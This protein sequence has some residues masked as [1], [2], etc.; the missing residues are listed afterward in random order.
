MAA[1]NRTN[2]MSTALVLLMILSAL[3]PMMA[4]H[5]G[6]ET[7]DDDNPETNALKQ[8]D[9]T[10]NTGG[11]APCPAVQS[12]AGTAGDAGN[13]TATA[14]SQGSDPTVT[15][16]DGCVDATDD[17]DWYSMQIS[18]NKDV[19]IVLRD[20]G[21]GTNIDFDLVVSDS[22]GGNPATGTGYVD[23][24]MTYSATERVEFT[25]NSTNAG[26][27]YLQIWQYAGDGN[28]KV[29][30]WVNNSVPKPDLSVN[31]ISGPVNAT[32]GDIVDVTY[33]IENFGPGDTNSTNPYDVVFIL[34]TDDTY[35]WS[36]TIVE[37][38]IAGPYLTAGSSSVETSQLTIPADIETDDYYWIVWPDGWG[39]VTEADDLNNNNASSAVT[40]ISGMPCPNEDDAATGGDVGDAEAEAYDLGAGFTGVITG[41]V[42]AGD[43]GDLYKL[44]MGRGQNI[45]A[46]L[47][48]DNW[49]ADIDLRLWN[50]STSGSTGLSAIDSSAGTASNESV[51]TAGSDADGA[52]DTYYINVTHYSGLANYTL[53]IW[54][55]GTIFIPPYDCGIDSD[56]GQSSYDAGAERS[57]AYDIGNNPEATGRACMDPADLTD[58]YRF[59][60]SGMQGS[61]IELESDNATDMHIELYQTENGVDQLIV[62]SQ[63]TNGVASVDTTSIPFDELD[64]NYFIL[65]NAIESGEQWD[66]GWYNL[67]FTPIAAPLPDLVAEPATCPIT[68]ET[69]GY[70]AP[71]M[72]QVSSVGGPMDATAFAWELS[73]V[74]EE[75][76]AVM[77]LLQGSYS[78][79]LEGNDGVIDQD[80]EQILLTNDISSGNYTCVLT[81]DGGD[82]IAESN[83]TNNV[84]TSLPFEIINEEE[85]Y[86][87]DVDRDGV[88]NDL[89]G[90]PNTPGDSTMDRLGCQDADGDGYSN[91]GDAFIYEPTQWNDTD[92]DLFGDNNGP[93]DY[94]GDDCPNE[95]GIASGTNG[96]GCPIWNP[97]ADG[98]GVPDLADDCPDTPAGATINQLGCTD[99]DGDG[100]YEPTDLCPETP[101]G[102]SVDDTGCAITSGDGNG[103]GSGDSGDSGDAEGTTDDGSNTLLYI[104]IA[105]SVVML[106]VVV[107]GATVLLRGGGNSDPTEQA[108]ATAISPEQQAYEQQLIGMGYTAEQA[109][110]Y[111][112]QYFQQ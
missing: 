86:A 85:L 10:M 79:A 49:D 48:A 69:T 95:P 14:K 47:S 30:I 74:N 103:D 46:V 44:S 80:G 104:I 84:W 110:A 98:D 60:L 3:A 35:D 20:F 23:Y 58:A 93:D 57:T 18:A 1:A 70:T 77:V 73:L 36:D 54:T 82:V 101:A 75:G 13:T 68:A 112:S 55:N 64:G 17:Q 89:D 107:L 25:T 105:A 16:M 100:V 67:T 22:T 31:S 52:A 92:G 42:A 53:E 106:I 102:T 4:P 33:T 99:L 9:R 91:G 65:V 28:Y 41:C 21:D 94:N 39:N 108:W 38:Q 32:A 59:S 76:T 26:M 11:R 61:T 40:T 62:E 12:D 111:A 5:F 6:I 96:T 34:S 78:D 43:K 51:T 56:W 90:C 45:T 37:S 88:P 8:A 87:D 63:M 81:V 27:H 24:S 97:D 15:N 19:V 109:R 7:V 83:E 72:A 66:T 29:D 50:T 71:F 2:R